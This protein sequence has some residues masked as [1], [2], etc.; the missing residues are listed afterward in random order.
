[1]AE[2]HRSPPP[3]ASGARRQRYKTMMTPTK[4]AAFRR[5][6]M[7][8]LVA[9]TT[10]PPRAG[11]TARARLKPTELSEMAAGSSA[12]GARSERMACH[13]GPFLV[14]PRPRP[15]GGNQRTHGPL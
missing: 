10:S 6:A 13:T 14:D 8:G 11:P 9:A 3:L 7:P 1:V 4:D 2:A 12:L 5:K 15:K